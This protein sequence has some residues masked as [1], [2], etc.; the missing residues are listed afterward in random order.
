LSEVRTP[1]RAE[2][3]GSASEAVDS[4]VRRVRDAADAWSGIGAPERAALLGDCLPGVVEVSESWVDAACLAKG[5]PRGGAVEAEEWI[6]GPMVT[7]RYVRLLARSLSEM[8]AA[9]A[10]TLRAAPGGRAVIGAFPCDVADRALYPGV[11][12]EVWLAPGSP[13][14]RGASYARTQRGPGAV[15]AVLGAGNI[16]SIPPLDVLYQLCAHNRVAVCKMNP[17]NA[18]LGP[19]LERAFA[20]LVERGFVAFIEGGV[21][22]GQALCSHPLVD[23][24]HVTGSI[25]THDAI[26]WGTTAAKRGERKAASRPLLDKPVTSELGCVTPVIV[27]PG[28]WKRD[29]LVTQARRVAAMV[30]HNASFNCNAAKLLVTAS[31]W[32]L[33]EEFLDA[34]RAELRAAQPRRAYY[35]GAQHRYQ[36]FLDRYPGAEVLGEA[37]NDVVPWTLIPG[38]PARAGE[39]ALS[40]E[41]FCGVIAETT[42]DRGGTSDPAGFLDAAV[43]LCNRSVWGDLSCAILVGGESERMLG[44]GLDR[45][46]AE[47]RYGAIGVNLWPGVVYGLG[48]PPWGAHPGNTLADARSGIGFVHNALLLDHPQKTVARGPRV[49]PITPPWFPDN[50]WVASIGPSLTRFEARR[51]V[52]N[53]ARLALSAVVG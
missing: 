32:Y 26:V 41:A 49:P 45:A 19:L 9:D 24:V 34:L 10:K 48:T 50:L 25:T 43:Q 23:A 18:Y 20:P 1:E 2:V 13:P 3:A 11:S 47:L 30:I 52:A 17:V 21:D 6:S 36:S 31:G 51:S 35:P 28:R 15:A 38:V 46:L 22:T 40:Q 27:V 53:L 33:R 14:T 37:G 12:A 39:L 42:L 44:D 5:E 7:A 4:V 29:E 16:G 8:P